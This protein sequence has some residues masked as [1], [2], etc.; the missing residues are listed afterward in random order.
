MLEEER[1]KSCLRPPVHP[2]T[3]ICLYSR[4][5]TRHGWGTGRATASLVRLPAAPAGVSSRREKGGHVC[6]PAL[7]T[8]KAASGGCWLDTVKLTAWACWALLAMCCMHTVCNIPA[9]TLPHPCTQSCSQAEVTVM[10]AGAAWAC[11][12]LLAIHQHTTASKE[13]LLLGYNP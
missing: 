8:G 6:S 10:A 7:L 3:A 9:T 4:E 12:V 5:A 11:W 2:S 13:T 1:V